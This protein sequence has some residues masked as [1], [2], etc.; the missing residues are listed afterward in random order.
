MLT[1][2]LV[3]GALSGALANAVGE[4]N[5]Y[6]GYIPSDDA[7][8]VAYPVLNPAGADTAY[9]NDNMSWEYETPDYGGRGY[10]GIS[11][12]GRFRKPV[13]QRRESG[14]AKFPLSA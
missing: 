8:N 9:P 11:F 7:G 10:D 6:A 14:T 1:P 4:G 3:P 5:V 2:N 13:L 12:Y